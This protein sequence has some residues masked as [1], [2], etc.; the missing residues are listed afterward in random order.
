MADSSDSSS[1]CDSPKKRKRGVFNKSAYK[2][3]IIKHA[4]VKGLKYTNSKGRT[5]NPLTP[6]ED[7][8]CKRKC[9]DKIS[10]EERLLIFNKFISFNTKNEQ[11]GYLQGQISVVEIKRRRPRK[12]ASN[13]TRPSRGSSYEYSISTCS[14][15]FI[16]GRPLTALPTSN[17]AEV[18]ESQIRRYERLERIRSQFWKRRQK[19]YLSEL[20]QRTK[21][22]QNAASL[23]V[24]DMVLLADD[25]A[26]PLA[27]K[28]GRVLRLITGPDGIARV[29]DV[30]TTKGSVRRSL[31]RLCKLPT[32]EELN[33]C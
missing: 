1:Y 15:H 4:R 29:A 25:N 13:T 23:D 14:G 18:K 9:Y 8:R 31:V 6:K 26:P 2:S 12:P 7:C 5:V 10:E 11:D 17:L 16:I 32:N 30:L 33:D 19:E 28:L 22:R 20:Q 21:W 27:W 3:E 24:G